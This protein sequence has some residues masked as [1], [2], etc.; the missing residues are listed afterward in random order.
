MEAKQVIVNLLK[1]NLK[2]D[3]LV[4]GVIVEI[5]EPA[6]KEVASKTPTKIDDIVLEAFIPQAKEELFKKIDELY[7]KIY[8]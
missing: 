6:I 5:L 4:K 8:S 7:G 2:I 3:E 1:E